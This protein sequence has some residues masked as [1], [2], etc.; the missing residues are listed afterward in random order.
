VGLP[1]QHAAVDVIG[2]AGDE[3]RLVARE[4]GDE[5]GD[6]LW[7]AQA[8][9]RIVFTIASIVSAGTAATLGPS[10][11]AGAI[12]FTVTPDDASSL[13][14]KRVMATMPAFDAA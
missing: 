9:D 4:V 1:H 14:A 13:A 3:A 11:A 5:R 10:I 6:L 8:A 2:R 7:P 12:A